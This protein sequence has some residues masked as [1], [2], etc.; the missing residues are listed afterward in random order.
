[1]NQLASKVVDWTISRLSGKAQILLT[2]YGLFAVA[3]LGLRRIPVVLLRGATNQSGRQ[4]TLLVAGHDPWV[5][6]LPSRF[7]VGKPQR[8]LVGNVL[9]W[10]LPA[11]LDRLRASADLTIARVDRLSAQK[12][13]GKDYLAVPEWVGMRLAVPEDLD[14]LVRCNRS[15]REDMRL[16]RKH[17]LQPLV[18][19]RE[20]RFQEFYD[21]MYVPFSRARHGAMAFVKSRYDLRRSLRKG[22]ILWVIRDKHPL[23]GMLFE[24]KNDTLDL[25][26]IGMAT[27]ELP[28][29]K[30]G[31][32]AALYY[33]SIA[34]AGQ[35][36]CAEVDFRG[37]RPSLHDGLVRYKRKWGNALYDKTDTSYDLLVRWN[38]VNGVVKDF[39]SHTGLIFRDERRLSAIHADES[40][41]R[42]SLWIG[43]LHQLYLLT[44]SGRQPMMD[45]G[46]S[47]NITAAGSDSCQ[48]Y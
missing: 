30:R 38:S 9:S 48:T 25:Q 43:G 4:G 34:H 1:M 7:F 3:R 21:S 28:L 41:S 6:Y 10:E 2:R 44:E 13:P 15:I 17:K 42:R 14:S 29:N 36:S 8:E 11:L 45:E 19:E 37:A 39:L 24:R 31:I 27:G 35:L 32:M 22:G 26:A 47:L 18:T 20:E 40:Q 5:S 16:V 12:F 33:Y 46:T 23:A